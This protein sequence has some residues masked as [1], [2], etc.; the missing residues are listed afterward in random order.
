MNDNEEGEDYYKD[1]LVIFEGNVLPC[2]ATAESVK[3]NGEGLVVDM[4]FMRENLHDNKY[5]G[6]DVYYCTFKVK[7]NS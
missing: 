7:Q 2:E 5:V 4:S 3:E 6:R 1:S